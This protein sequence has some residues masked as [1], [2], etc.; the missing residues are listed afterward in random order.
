MLEE[1]ETVDGQKEL[2]EEDVDKLEETQGA[3]AEAERK[4]EIKGEVRITDEVITMLVGEI[5]KDIEGIKGTN[6]GLV[7]GLKFGKKPL[8][9]GVKIEVEEGK[10]PKVKVDTYI[11]IKY[12]LRIPD[13]AWEVQEKVKT[14]LEEYTGYEVSE[15]NIYVQGLMFGNGEEKT[16]IGETSHEEE[17]EVKEVVEEHNQ[18]D[19]SK[20]EQV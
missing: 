3:E 15:V 14:K 16:A 10:P 12:G 17:E 5:L 2:L 19:E 7:G 11:L 9:D 13:I 8:V 1:K 18:T 20:D 6:I 4:Q